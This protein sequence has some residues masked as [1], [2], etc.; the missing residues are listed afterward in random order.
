MKKKLACPKKQRLLR[1]DDRVGI[2]RMH[3]IVRNKAT[4]LLWIV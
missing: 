3:Y 2:D 1:I 4:Y